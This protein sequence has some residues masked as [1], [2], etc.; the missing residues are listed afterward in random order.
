M[1]GLIAV[2]YG[3]MKEQT[4]AQNGMSWDEVWKADVSFIIATASEC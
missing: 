2:R 3:G 4:C 1:L